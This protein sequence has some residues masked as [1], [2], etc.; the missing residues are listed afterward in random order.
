[1]TTF[2]EADFAPKDRVYIDGC[3][4]LI[5]VITAVT[6]RHCWLVNYEVSWV[7]QGKAESAIIEG[8]RLSPVE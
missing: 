2:I 8:W 5:G 6:W 3:K 1:M 7:C 4:D